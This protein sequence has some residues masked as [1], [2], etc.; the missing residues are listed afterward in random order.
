M[1]KNLLVF[2]LAI[3]FLSGCEGNT[4]TF[5]DQDNSIIND[6]GSNNTDQYVDYN[7]FSFYY[8]EDT[9]T[10]SLRG[11][12]GDSVNVVVPNNYNDIPVSTIYESAF[13]GGFVSVESIELPE[14]LI[15]FPVLTGLFDLKTVNIPTSISVLPERAFSNCTSLLN[16]EIPES[17]IEIDERCFYSSG[18][19]QITIPDSVQVIG[20][21]AFQNCKNLFSVQL[22]EGISEISPELFSGCTSLAEITIPSNVSKIGEKAFSR[23]QSLTD[24][25]LPD[26]LS[27]F[28]GDDNSIYKTPAKIHITSN[29]ALKDFA[30]AENERLAEERWIIE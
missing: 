28:D 24:V 11:Y 13:R 21:M 22:S 18:L 3:T 6:S 12:L 4:S 25:Y 8:N 23:C 2:M 26:G 5:E 20:D 16:I 30:I 19:K 15:E 10:Y 14:S 1:K 29:S 17:V 7:G 27:E 9:N